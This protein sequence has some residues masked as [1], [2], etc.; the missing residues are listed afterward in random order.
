MTPTRYVWIVFHVVYGGGI[1]AKGA[2]TFSEML[3]VN[4]HSCTATG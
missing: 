1:H 3:G 2:V 4:I